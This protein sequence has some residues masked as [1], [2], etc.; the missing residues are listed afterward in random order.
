MRLPSAQAFEGY[1]PLRRGFLQHYMH[2]RITRTEAWVFTCLVMQADPRWGIVWTNSYVLAREH[3]MSRSFAR[4]IL[5]SLAAKG[6]IRRFPKRRSPR[7]YPVLID[8]FFITKGTYKNKLLDAF[9]SASWGERTYRAVPRPGPRLIPFE[10]TASTDFSEEYT[11]QGDAQVPRLGL[12]SG[13]VLIERARALKQKLNTKP[14]SRV[15]TPHAPSTRPQRDEAEQRRIVEARDRRLHEEAQTQANARVG[16][17]PELP[18]NV[19]TARVSCLECRDD[20]NRLQ[21]QRCLAGKG[22]RGPQTYCPR[23]PAPAPPKSVKIEA[24]PAVAEGVSMAAK[25]SS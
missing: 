22:P 16:A 23:N 14:K 11:S 10:Q 20:L 25:N 6:Y 1:I 3:H 9:A 8:K 19:N 24:K 2:G 17:G 21:F 13:D 4:K 5:E 7:A 18:E 15:P 12:D